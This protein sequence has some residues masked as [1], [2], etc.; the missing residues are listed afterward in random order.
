M[1]RRLR[2]PS[3]AFFLSLV[4]LF[5]ALG[6]TTYAAV[7]LPKNSV[8]TKQ[9]K[10]NAVT[11]VKIKKGGVTASKINTTGLTVPNALHATNATHATSA[12]SA[13]AHRLRGRRA[14][15]QL[16]I[17]DHRTSLGS[18]GHRAQPCNRRGPVHRTRTA[19]RD[20]L[21]HLEC[22]LERRDLCRRG[23]PVLARPTRGRSHPGRGPLL[24]YVHQW[25]RV[26]IV[27][28]A[29]GRPAEGAAVVPGGHRSIGGIVCFGNRDPRRVP[30]ELHGGP[31]LQWCC[32]AV[33]LGR[34]RHRGLYRRR[35]VSNRCLTRRTAPWSG[36][37]TRRR[38]GDEGRAR[39][40]R[41]R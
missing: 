31:V 11:S 4:A 16:S 25:L 21:R 39:R 6:G 30:R 12:G 35:G 37:G 41:P 36:S 1:K 34:E 18:D 20:L 3:P 32:C 2:A 29:A 7:T 33:R 23:C 40:P 15:R 38:A 24:D 14:G 26:R 28:S 8:G 22:P 17:T 5:V 10:K 19:A 9:L 13:A 27:L